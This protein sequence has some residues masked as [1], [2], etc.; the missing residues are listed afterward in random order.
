TAAILGDRPVAP[1]SG[2]ALPLRMQQVG[3][4]EAGR[5]VPVGQHAACDNRAMSASSPSVPRSPAAA[6]A[7]MLS[8]VAL[9]SLMD[10]GMKLLSASYPT[11]Q[12]TMLRGA[13]SLPF[14][15]VWVLATAGPRS[16]VP[17]RWGLHLLRGALGMVMIGCFVYALRSLPLSTAYSI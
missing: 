11:L 16:L 7:W 13:A 15:L 9:F 6:V 1:P 17:V 8:A 10:A 4:R 14:V 3:Y 5:R 2:R 12:V